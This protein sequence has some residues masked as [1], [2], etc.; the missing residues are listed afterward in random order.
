MRRVRIAGG[1]RTRRASRVEVARP[2]PEPTLA[3]R[4]GPVAGGHAVS[5]HRTS[6][7]DERDADE[8][9]DAITARNGR[10]EADAGRADDPAPP[11][12]LRLELVLDDRTDP[13]DDLRGSSVDADA[14]PPVADADS[15][16][17][18]REAPI[19]GA[20]PATAAP[21][22]DGVTERVT[23]ADADAGDAAGTGP[24]EEPDAAAELARASDADAATSEPT[25]D[26]DT[27]DDAEPE[28][29]AASGTDAPQDAAANPFAARAK[30]ADAAPAP[31]PIE[32]TSGLPPPV[33]DLR[34]AATTQTLVD[35]EW[36]APSGVAPIGYD[37]YRDGALRARTTQ[38]GFLDQAVRPGVAYRYSVSAV[39]G[40]GTAARPS[41]TLVVVAG[42]PALRDARPPSP[43][44]AVIV[45]D[46]G[47]GL[48]VTWQPGSDDDAVRGYE[49]RR[50]GVHV[51]TSFSSAWF[52]REAPATNAA[53]EIV[54]FDRAGNLSRASVT[55]SVSGTLPYGVGDAMA[56]VPNAV[57]DLPP[58]LGMTVVNESGRP[59]VVVSAARLD[60][61]WRAGRTP[62]SVRVS[63]DGAF[64]PLQV[65]VLDADGGQVEQLLTVEL[66][67]DPAGAGAAVIR[68]APDGGLLVVQAG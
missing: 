49:V 42:D 24:H 63:L 40:A 14:S 64:A 26:G 59:V 29:P 18:A 19:D 51:G 43:P 46:G 48:L 39:M 52:D 17:S 6:P 56:A 7:A 5:T 44:S 55:A 45:R 41:A 32:T 34:V 25:D 36:S 68:D 53:Y 31:D 1:E 28:E 12:H 21:S 35:L 61:L 38:P 30:E 20:E 62:R 54:A 16:A 57:T 65:F 47:A 13:A 4:D 11:R 58:E 15:V 66:P 67:A 2:A 10:T 50:N 22:A 23:D 8:L 9:D 27:G 33:R 3:S 37:L 60:G